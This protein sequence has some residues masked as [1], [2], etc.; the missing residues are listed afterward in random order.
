MRPANKRRRYNVTSSLIGWGHTQNDP[1]IIPTHS[2]QWSVNTHSWHLDLTHLSSLNACNQCQ[3][4][5]KIFTGLTYKLLLSF[6]VIPEVYRSFIPNKNY[7]Y[8][9]LPYSV[10]SKLPGSFEIHAVRQ[11][12][13]NFMGL[14]SIVNTTVYKTEP[15]LTG[16]GHGELS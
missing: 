10:D 3:K 15:I 11:Y 6:T 1:C 12:L 13:V 4:L 7:I 9:V 16:L 5:G 14:A 8:Q 2:T